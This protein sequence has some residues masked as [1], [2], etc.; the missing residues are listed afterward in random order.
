[1]REHAVKIYTI[2]LTAGDVDRRAF[3][4]PAEYGSFL[5]RS[6]AQKEP[7]TQ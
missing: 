7:D 4:G 6:L 3:Q 2:I 1:M 5:S